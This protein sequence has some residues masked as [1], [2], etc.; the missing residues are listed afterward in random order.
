MIACSCSHSLIGAASYW[1]PDMGGCLARRHLDPALKQEEMQNHPSPSA[2]ATGAAGAEVPGVDFTQVGVLPL[3][4]LYE[5]LLLLPAK[6]LCRFRAVCRLWRFLLSDQDFISAHAARHPELLILAD[7]TMDSNILLDIMDL[8]GQ[9]IK[10]VCK[11][12]SDAKYD[13]AVSGQFDLICV[14][15]FRRKCRL[16]HLAT[17]AVCQLPEELACGHLAQVPDIENYS[18]LHI[19]W[20]QV[21]ST[22][23][24]KV[25][26]VLD[27]FCNM[28][29]RQ[30][31]EVLTLSGSSHARWRE[32]KAP[33]DLVDTNPQC[34]VA[35]GGIVYFFLQKKMYGDV[36]ADRIASFDLETEEWRPSIRGPVSTLV[37]NTPLPGTDPLVWGSLSICALNSCLVVV[38]QTFR[39]LITTD[40]WF[41]IDLEKGLWVKQNSLSFSASEFWSP[42][43]LKPLNDGRIIAYKGKT[44]LFKIYDPRTNTYSEVGDLHSH[45]V[46][47]LYK[48]SL[49]SLPNAVFWREGCSNSRQRTGD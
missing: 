4:M 32:K 10:R 18:V 47:G 21:A 28:V 31:C 23:G 43:L 2:V 45:Y 25:L 6:T 27:A 46:L 11:T 1:G 36:M 7:S 33:P 15:G 16:Q 44:G 20:G 40:L 35:I 9:V 14:Q 3:D 5:V 30:L 48:G 29:P 13:S 49:L 24:H 8:S 41:L 38:H 19:A 42:P 17:G 26:R 34:T 22:G 12:V 39:Q 37:D